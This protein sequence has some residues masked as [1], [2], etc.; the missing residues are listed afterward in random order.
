[1]QFY[2]IEIQDVV[3]GNHKENV[4]YFHNLDLCQIKA[5]VALKPESL[6]G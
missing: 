6:L 3:G 4:F 1:M 2:H 5:K